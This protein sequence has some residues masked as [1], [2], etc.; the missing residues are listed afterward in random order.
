M[1]ETQISVTVGGISLFVGEMHAS[2]MR[3]SITSN[4]SGKVTNLSALHRRNTRAPSLQSVD[5]IGMV[6]N[7]LQLENDSGPEGPETQDC[8]NWQRCIVGSQS[9]NHLGL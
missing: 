5:G 1:I 2:N 3:S 9:L 8:L 4:V 7:D 6:A